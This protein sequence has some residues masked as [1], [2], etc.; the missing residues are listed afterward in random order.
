MRLAQVLRILHSWITDPARWRMVG[1][2]G[3]QPFARLVQVLATP[4]WVSDDCRERR[5][6][7]ALVAHGAAV[8]D[9]VGPCREADSPHAD[10][11]LEMVEMPRRKAGLQSPMQG[12]C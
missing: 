5:S 4:A 10:R 8:Q 3:G 9:L 1:P 6:G 7:Y 11:S 12:D 2:S